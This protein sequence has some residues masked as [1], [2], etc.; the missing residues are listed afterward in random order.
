MINSVG[1]F[2]ESPPVLRDVRIL[3]NTVMVAWGADSIGSFFHRKSSSKQISKAALRVL[4]RL[5]HHR[6]KSDFSVIILK[7]H[8]P[9][10]TNRDYI[11]MAHITTRMVYLPRFMT[12]VETGA[13]FTVTDFIQLFH[14]QGESG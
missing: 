11:I 8:F 10:F 2:S 14:N 3:Q 5:L 4:K 6:G 7:S 13:V 9:A 12:K 1:L